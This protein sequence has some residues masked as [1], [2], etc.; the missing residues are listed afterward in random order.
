MPKSLSRKQKR[1]KR[2]K[3][4][5]SKRL[6]RG[7]STL[8]V[9]EQSLRQAQIELSTIVTNSDRN[10]Q[11]MGL[12][13][14]KS[15]AQRE[16]QNLQ[17]QIDQ[18][19]RVVQQQYQQQQPMAPVRPQPY[20]Q[21]YQ[22]QQQPMAPVRPQYQQPMAPILPQYQQPIL[23]QPYPQ[24]QQPAL[25]A[26]QNKLA[27][28]KKA[29]SNAAINSLLILEKRAQ[30]KV[31]TLLAD[32]EKKQLAAAQNPTNTSRLLVAGAQSVLESAKKEL[33]R[34][35]DAKLNPTGTNAV[36]LLATTM[37]SQNNVRG[38]LIAQLSSKSK[39]PKKKL[40]QYTMKDLLTYL[41]S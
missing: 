39:V 40:M 35:Q 27:A 15:L 6:L 32:L 26:S 11:D 34:I 28:N 12:Q 4:Q 37:K 24:L 14:A 3:K 8:G 22:Q 20:Q 41:G 25:F 17:S 29:A 31:K 13:A 36:L 23:P 9:L 10:P 16:V 38:R 5:R 1:S 18:A 30:E 21:Q 2:S 19:R 7:G 33:Q